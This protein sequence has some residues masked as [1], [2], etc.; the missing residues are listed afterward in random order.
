MKQHRTGQAVFRICK[1]SSH[2][3]LQGTAAYQPIRR[4]RKFTKHKPITYLSD[5]WLAKITRNMLVKRKEHLKKLKTCRGP[6]LFLNLYPCMSTKAHSSSWHSPVKLSFCVQRFSFRSFEFWRA[7]I[8]ECIGTYFLLFLTS[9]GPEAASSSSSTDT[10]SYTA[11]SL[12]AKAASNLIY[13]I[14]HSR[15]EK[16]YKFA[17]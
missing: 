5:A 1:S 15:L 10:S 16:S 12:L 17:V 13:C 11:D 9:C 7:V 8:A 4:K 14:V 2:W 6:S 3:V